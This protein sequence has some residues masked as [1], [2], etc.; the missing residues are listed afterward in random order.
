MWWEM[1]WRS[2]VRSCLLKPLL[3]R[4]KKEERGKTSSSR[5][6]E[7]NRPLFLL[8]D[9]L[10]QKKPFFVK[11]ESK[12]EI[13]SSDPQTSISP[14][15]AAALFCRKREKTLKAFPG[16]QKLEKSFPRPLSFPLILDPRGGRKGEEENAASR[17]FSFARGN[18]G[19]GKRSGLGA[20]PFLVA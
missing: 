3:L 16:L 18:S 13:S 8:K 2:V 7:V 15:S 20:S 11:K 6:P 1:K 10:R 17:L 14:C 19:G 4:Q 5:E 9:L 12:W